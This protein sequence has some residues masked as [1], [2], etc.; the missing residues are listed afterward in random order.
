MITQEIRYITLQSQMADRVSPELYMLR[1]VKMCSP[2][3]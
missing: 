2:N 1:N 3:L